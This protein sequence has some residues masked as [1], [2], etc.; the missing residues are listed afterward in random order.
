[1]QRASAGSGKTYTL[2]KRYIEFYLSEPAGD[3]KRRLRPVKELREALH[4]ILAITFTNKATNEM[5]LRI[6]AKLNAIAMWQPGMPTDKT[7]YLEEFMKEFDCSAQEISSYCKYALKVLLSD[8]SDFKVSTIDSFFQTVLRTFAYEAELDDTYQIELDSNYVTQMGLD[9]TLDEIET[10]DEVTEGTEW[11][12]A[13]METKA[14]SG[15]GWNI[16][17]K[18]ANRYSIYGEILNASRNL[19]KED[20]KEIRESLDK[21]FDEHPDFYRT[22]HELCKLYEK[23]L[24]EAHAEMRKAAR[25]VQK[26]FADAGLNIETQGGYLLAGRVAKMASLWKWDKTLDKSTDFEPK[27][28]TRKNKSTRVFN[29]EVENP[30]LNSE[31]EDQIEKLATRMYE[32]FNIWRTEAKSEKLK[33][34]K[35]YRSTMPYVGLLQNVRANSRLF[36][37]DSNTVELGETNSILSRIIGDDDA[38]FVYER[39]GSRL[40]HFLID[41]FQDTSSLQWHNLRPLLIESESNGKEN[42][43][44]GD[45]KQSIYRFRN[46]DPSLITK[47]VPEQFADSCVPCG[48]TP[49]ENT[50]WRSSLKVVKFNN[51]FFRYFSKELGERLEQLYFN[52]VQPASH[53][54]DRGYVEVQLFKNEKSDDNIPAHFEDIPD[55]IAD[56][57]SRG[58]HMNEIAILVDTHE[59]G[60]QVIAKIMEYNQQDDVEEKIN[61]ISADSLETGESP[62]VQTVISILEAINN[63]T[64]AEL[65]PLEE[66]RKKGVGDWSKLRAD[67]SFFAM[68]NPGTPLSELLTRFINGEF[69]PDSISEIMGGMFTTVLPALIENIIITFLPEKTRKSEAAFLAALQDLT[70]EFCERTNADIASFL[71]WWNK[72]GKFKSISSPEGSNAVNIMTVHKSKGL[73]FRCV[74]V[75]YSK[76]TT[77]PSTFQREW[78]WVKPD[79]SDAEGLPHI[80]WIPVWSEKRLEETIH[81]KIYKDYLANYMIDKVNMAYVAYTRAVDELYIFSP[82]DLEEGHSEDTSKIGHYLWHCGKDAETIINDLREKYPQAAEYLPDAKDIHIDEDAW[83]WSYGE[84]PTKEEIESLRNKKEKEAADKGEEDK[85]KTLTIS[86]FRG[87]TPTVKLHLKELISLDRDILPSDMREDKEEDSEPAYVR[88]YGNK[89]HG[90]MEAI[91]T[92]ADLH[93]A[94]LRLKAAGKIGKDEMEHLEKEIGQALDSVK[95]YGWFDPGS[96]VLTERSIIGIGDKAQRPD[97]VLLRQDGTAVIVDYKFGTHR[98]DQAYMRQVNRYGEA[99]IKAGLAKKYEAYIWYVSLGEVIGVRD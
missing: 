80:P 99:L 54:A 36:L 98:K 43:I 72:K 37:T 55:L 50:N 18:N 58:Y 59:Q 8:Y 35:I 92:P 33:K 69:N 89:M 70:I 21:Y 45:A 40:E 11:I 31:T 44:I 65:R 24:R 62:A 93:I 87:H 68:Q 73:E 52:T 56:M 27:A 71:D 64:H 88:E 46:A 39:L 49:K 78:L 53:K 67:F 13:M 10:Q 95:D 61:F 20:F 63:G 48:N 86:D 60:T 94:L 25:E 29:P 81:A 74:I 51:L 41:E 38:P 96:R 1:M 32:K 47:T 5:K 90:I 97:R 2:A 12:G 84:K 66:R 57:L 4:R 75:P 23:D 83:S 17:Q 26:A 42:L 77:T 82:Y 6:V 3:G 14:L 9:T 85:V 79:L 15:K 30:Y 7:D 34:W 16:F 76:Q 22:F 91:N 28:F 19:A